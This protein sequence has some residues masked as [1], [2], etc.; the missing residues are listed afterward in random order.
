MSSFQ[1][2]Q[3]MPRGIVPQ[4]AM[5]PGP[6]QSLQLPRRTMVPRAR[7]IDLSI[8]AGSA[9]PDPSTIYTLDYFLFH[10]LD[11]SFQV[12]WVSAGEDMS[13]ERLTLQ[14]VQKQDQSVVE[15]QQELRFM[16]LL[17][18]PTR[19]D[20]CGPWSQGPVFVR[21]ATKGV[22]DATIYLTVYTITDEV[23]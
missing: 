10:P 1:P 19:I 4:S 14:L 17:I 13:F 23:A 3:Y 9:T 20:E 18:D 2:F 8:I 7:E 16:N 6:P 15:L 12:M 21:V 22:V 11:E 5:P